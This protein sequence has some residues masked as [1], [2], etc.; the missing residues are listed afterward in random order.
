[1]DNNSSH[2]TTYVEI[3]KYE[4]NLIDS[5]TSSIARKNPNIDLQSGNGRSGRLR[6][7]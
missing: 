3:L 1:M 5:Q 4:G 6:I 2:D 7:A